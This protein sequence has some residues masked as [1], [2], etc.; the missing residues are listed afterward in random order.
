[1]GNPPLENQS[2]EG[3]FLSFMMMVQP[4]ISDPKFNSRCTTFKA[5]VK[6]PLDVNWIDDIIDIQIIHDPH[7]IL[8][9]LSDLENG[10]KSDIFEL[11]RS[12]G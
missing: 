11:S 1:M 5:Y 9:H 3:C 10:R 4:D 2:H 6:L 8:V 12:R 7:D